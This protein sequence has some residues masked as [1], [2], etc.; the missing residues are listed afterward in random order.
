MND[1]DGSG[2]VTVEEAM[3]ILY[4]RHGNDMLDEQ[5]NEIFGTS[6]TSSTSNLNLTEFLHSLYMSQIKQLKHNPVSGGSDPS[7]RNSYR[8]GQSRANAA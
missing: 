5:L 8:R 4:L 1:R 3:Q 7:P 2:V 6:D